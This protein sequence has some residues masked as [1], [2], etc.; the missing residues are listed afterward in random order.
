MWPCGKGTGSAAAQTGL[1]S[2]YDTHQ[3]E[4]LSKLL[5]PLACFLT[6]EMGK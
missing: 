1:K 6:C 5:I 3:R 2:P 4:A